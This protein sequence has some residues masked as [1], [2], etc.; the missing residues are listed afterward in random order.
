MVNSLIQNRQIR[1][2][3]SSTFKDMQNERDHLMKFTFPKLR[4]LASQRDVILTELDLR[5][6]ITQEEAENGRIIDICLREI[7]SS[8]PFFIGIIGNRYGWI[9]TWQDVDEGTLERFC[10][11]NEY[12]KREISVTEMEMQYGVLERDEE[13]AAYFFIKDE[14]PHDQEEKLTVLKQK[15]V[16]SRY[17]SL[18]YE[19]LEQLSHQVEEAFISVLDKYYP[20][21]FLSQVEK[22]RINQSSI[23]NQLCSSYIKDERNFET[24][25]R[26]MADSTS[27]HLVITGCSGT[28]KSALI[29]NWLKERQSQTNELKTV[30][31][32]VANNGNECSTEFIRR[33]LLNEIIDQ[34]GWEESTIS[35]MTL[36]DALL[37]IS[38]DEEKP[39][40]IVLDAV[41]Q[42][43]DIEDAKLLNWIPEPSSNVKILMS[44]IDGDKTMEVAR[45]RNYDIFEISP[46]NI[47]QRKRLIEVYLKSFGKRLSEAQIDRIVSDSQCGNTMVLKTLLNELIN[48]GIFEELDN[49]ISYFLGNETIES[50]YQALLQS[51]ETDFSIYGNN[52]I[53]HTLSLIAASSN[54]LTE[55]EILEMT[56]QKQLH[57]SQFHCAFIEHFT[58]KHGKIS[59]SHDYIL[60]SVCARYLD[61]QEY[62]KKIQD[63]IITY[64]RSHD[65]ARSWNELAYQYHITGRYSDMWQ[66]LRRSEV[67]K[68]FLYNAR[69]RLEI[70]WSDI[71]SGCDIYDLTV[72]LDDLKDD[73]NTSLE[74]A[75]FIGR[76]E[77]RTAL[78]YMQQVYDI[79]HDADR[80]YFFKMLG[81]IYSKQSNQCYR[82]ALTI[83]EAEGKRNT[84][85]FAD[86]I[87][88]VATTNS[89]IGKSE[90]MPI[91]SDEHRE[92]ILLEI[93]E[94][95]ALEAK[96]IQEE[97][98]ESLRDLGERIHEGFRQIEE[99][100][101]PFEEELCFDELQLAY[102]NEAI[103]IARSSDCNISYRIASYYSHIFDILWLTTPEEYMT[104]LEEALAYFIRL[105]T[106]ECPEV[107]KVL[108]A[109]AK[110]KMDGA[111][112]DE[113]IESSRKIYGH[114]SIEVAEAL[115]EQ[116]MYYDSIKDFKSELECY[117]EMLDIYT[118]LGME[119]EAEDILFLMSD[120]SSS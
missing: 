86:M 72:Y 95:E 99:Y 66:L 118:R 2:F 3:I 97:D 4:A 85:D 52:V 106:R 105:K 32:F 16:E 57:W 81:D 64:F 22:D 7:D 111:I 41:N 37:K 49:R 12:I 65:N 113:I 42:I 78:M 115:D 98:N 61:D 21:G 39:L 36:E 19:S 55:E 5:W 14:E 74:F 117:K 30:Y 112:Y 70:Y 54:G 71:V 9:P 1:I 62:L 82:K 100:R 96:R 35:K 67:M 34:Y 13:M 91:E 90:S 60:A 107:I 44:T 69:E 89:L 23:M 101:F 93:R 119:E 24:I 15:I 6:G 20:E 109:I 27:R 18:R 56:G 79:M 31:H 114:Y 26:W 10:I 94:Q 120:I 28:G 59:F 46:L 11:V 103:R 102:V 83:L 38:A 88:N 53:R 25:D 8:V 40:L 51:Y 84:V 73:F 45:N 108:R 80:A 77:W 48:F 116:A 92:E 29:A 75:G 33:R 104:W 63:Q 87:I 50:F 17:P 58:N 43:A 110:V 76:Q 68:H 47:D